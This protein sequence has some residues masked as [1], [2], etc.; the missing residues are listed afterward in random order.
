[1]FIEG[2]VNFRDMG[3]GATDEGRQMRRGRVYRSGTMHAIT[4]RGLDA[5]AALGIRDAFDLRSNAERT[6]R[7]SRLPGDSVAYHFHDHDRFTGNIFQTLKAFAGANVD[8]ADLMRNVYRRLPY[9][10]AE[11][12]RWL[13]QLMLR[14][15]GPV[16]FNCAAGKDRTG[17]AAALLLA[18]LG[19]SKADIYVDYLKTEEVFDLIVDMFLT[20]PRG[21][22]VSDVK[23]TLWEPVMHSDPTYLDAMFAAVDE[24]SGSVSAYFENELRIDPAELRARL[25]D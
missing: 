15:N 22:L 14:G 3:G 4:D 2:G 5:F 25:L 18:T 7:P 16:V 8:G 10:F 13:F 1:L 19:V 17:A 6:A 12:Y 21:V 20:G 9:E 24:Q 23:R 11:S